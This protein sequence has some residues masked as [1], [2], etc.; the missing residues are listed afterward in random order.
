MRTVAR[1]RVALRCLSVDDCPNLASD[2]PVHPSSRVHP[3]PLHALTCRWAP[4]PFC[5]SPQGLR[6]G[7][8]PSAARSRAGS[9]CK[10]RLE[11]RV[12]RGVDVTLVPSRPALVPT[13]VS[14]KSSP[15][16]LAPGGSLTLS[17]PQPTGAPQVLRAR[18][19]HE[20][21][22]QCRGHR[23]PV[24]AWAPGTPQGALATHKPRL[25][26]PTNTVNA[27]VRGVRRAFRHESCSDCPVGVESFVSCCAAQRRKVARSVCRSVCPV[28]HRRWYAARDRQRR[29][30]TPN[31]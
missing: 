22:R 20:R 12:V 1:P 6:A 5:L 23:H 8:C 26:P 14:M 18:P 28:C 30:H 4:E 10:D 9:I 11:P 15:R 3:W 19:P 24:P 29:G 27:K 31:L 16:A 21:G 2:D 17:A 7:G 25:L 13:P